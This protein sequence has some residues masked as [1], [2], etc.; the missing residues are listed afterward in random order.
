M[1]GD[2]MAKNGDT[3]SIHYTGKLKDNSVFDSS[4]D[5]DPLVFELGTPN[6]IAGFNKAVVGMKA[7]ESKTISI[8]P[9]EG[10]GTYDKKLVFEV[11]LKNLPA[12]VK[13]GAML[14]NPQG[15]VVAVKEINGDKAVLDANHQLAGKTLFFDIKLV[16]IK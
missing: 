12:G 7:G 1:A 6:I 14:R 8:P 13:S 15:H 5:R 9:E 16:H 4:K 10:Y 3:V 11:P 2:R